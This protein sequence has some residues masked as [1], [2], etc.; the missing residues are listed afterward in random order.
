MALL[1][2][3]KNMWNEAKKKHNDAHLPLLKGQEECH[4][5]RMRLSAQPAGAE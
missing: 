3:K 5:V 2:I 1:F 4:R